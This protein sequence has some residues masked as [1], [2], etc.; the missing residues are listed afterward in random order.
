MGYSSAASSSSIAES[1]T[2]GLSMA[3]ADPA[4][5]GRS[6]EQLARRWCACL[7]S[8]QCCWQSGLRASDLAALERRQQAEW[9][10]AGADDSESDALSMS[11]HSLQSVKPAARMN[12]WGADPPVTSKALELVA[13]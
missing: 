8:V 10:L 4:W 12:N 11:M 1:M 7:Q 13:R 5:R 2:S 3:S 6:H 9:A